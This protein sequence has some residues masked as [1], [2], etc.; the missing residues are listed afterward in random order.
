MAKSS[1]KVLR[2][3]IGV[4]TELSEI[5]RDLDPSRVRQ[6]DKIERH[7]ENARGEL[8]RSEAFEQ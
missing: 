5:V 1:Q 8:T 4:V 6:Y 3:L 7:L 2:E